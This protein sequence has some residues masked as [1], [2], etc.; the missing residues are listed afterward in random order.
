MLGM[1][2]VLDKLPDGYAIFA[3]SRG[4]DT[5]HVSPA[6]EPTDLHA[7]WYRLIAMSMVR[8]ITI[9]RPRLNGSEL[10]LHGMYTHEVLR[11]SSRSSAETVQIIER[12]LP[13]FQAPYG[14][15]KRCRLSLQDLCWRW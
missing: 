6:D 10:G 7:D 2:Y 4:N 15:W 5:T 8:S 11:P 9:H 3:K 1:T 13:P 14:S 12:I